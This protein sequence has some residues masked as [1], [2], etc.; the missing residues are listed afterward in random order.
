MNNFFRNI[1]LSLFLLLLISCVSNNK[2]INDDSKLI[3]LGKEYTHIILTN[4]VETLDGYYHIQNDSLFFISKWDY[5]NYYN[6][7]NSE[8]FYL[9]HLKPYFLFSLN[10]QE[11]YLSERNCSSLDPS[12]DGLDFRDLRNIFYPPKKIDDS[13]Y[14][15]E[16]HAVLYG[17][18][19]PYIRV[20]VVTKDLKIKSFS[21]EGKNPE[22]YFFYN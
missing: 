22:Y 17:N 11:P 19:D 4:D 8:V 14:T 18:T 12:Y 13:T 20:F 6:I 16:Q 10:M 1:M 3:I 5:N 2:L 15:F 7:L 9:D 21:T